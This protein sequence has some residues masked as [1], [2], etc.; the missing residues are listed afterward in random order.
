MTFL[1]WLGVF[2][3]VF[4]AGFCA[5]GFVGASMALSHAHDTL[6]ERNDYTLDRLKEINRKLA[7]GGTQ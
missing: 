5:G 3:A 7:A 4:G 1:E 2:C 6:G